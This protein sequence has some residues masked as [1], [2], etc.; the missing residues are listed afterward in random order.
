MILFIIFVLLGCVS[1]STIPELAFKEL[2]EGDKLRV[3]RATP[4]QLVELYIEGI[5]GNNPNLSIATLSKKT[6][7]GDHTIESYKESLK[8]GEITNLVIE[9]VDYSEL[10]LEKDRWPEYMLLISYNI[11]VSTGKGPSGE[12]S[13][14]VSFIKENNI[15]KIEH[16]STSP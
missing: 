4:V 16:F 6:N 9:E 12:Q 2:S 7:F 1:S 3:E 8:F 14:F 11:D 13:Y 15:W 5:N 10:N